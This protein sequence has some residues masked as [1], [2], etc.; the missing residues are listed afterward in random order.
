[1]AHLA[2]SLTLDQRKVEM[3]GKQKPFVCVV[4]WDCNNLSH[5]D[6]F[7][8]MYPSV[9]GSLCASHMAHTALNILAY[10]L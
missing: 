10:P 8:D 2:K 7:T 6:R 1:M 5:G 9:A 4:Y 3:E